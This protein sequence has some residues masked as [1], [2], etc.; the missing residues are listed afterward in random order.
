[1]ITI[2][3]GPDLAEGGG[4]RAELPVVSVAL[5]GCFLAVLAVVVLL[6]AAGG[7]AADAGT[8]VSR[9]EMG[10]EW[11]LTVPEG[12]LRCDAGSEVTFQAD[13]TTYTLN[14]PAADSAHSSIGPLLLD[15]GGGGTKDIRPLLERG[16]RLCD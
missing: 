7:P 6:V 13:G 11:P 16:L 15:G 5:V 4:E 12:L 3:H 14:R 10:D 2:D 1:M 9:A 8:R